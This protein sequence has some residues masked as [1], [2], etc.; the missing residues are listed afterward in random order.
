MHKRINSLM[1]ETLSCAIKREECFQ[2]LETLYER[3]VT[4][5]RRGGAESFHFYFHGSLG[6][7]AKG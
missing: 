6:E 3:K 5:E 7:A 2:T 4:I 1:K